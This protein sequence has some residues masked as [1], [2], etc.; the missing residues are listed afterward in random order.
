MIPK[1]LFFD[2]WYHFFAPKAPFATREETDDEVIANPIRH[3]PIITLFCIF[4]E[5]LL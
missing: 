3:H 5:L 4:K 1:H 2:F